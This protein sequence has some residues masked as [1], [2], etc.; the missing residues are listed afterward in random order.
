MSRWFKTRRRMAAGLMA[1]GLLAAAVLGC[2]SPAWAADARLCDA[3][4]LEAI[5]LAKQVREDGCGFDLTNP[6]WSEDFNAHNRWCRSANVESVD[7]ERHVR[8]VN[9][10]ICSQCR[11]YA[12]NARLDAEAAS[13]NK[14]NMA[15]DDAV[16]SLAERA[17][18]ST[19]ED[20]H[21]RWCAGLNHTNPG[22]SILL[23]G[24]TSEENDARS[25]VV[26]DCGVTRSDPLKVAPPTREVSKPF[27]SSR[28]NLSR[29]APG[30]P[31]SRRL[32]AS[33]PELQGT[34]RKSKELKSSQ[35]RTTRFAPCIEGPGQ[36]CG[37]NRGVVGPGLLEG[38]GGFAGQGPS[39]IGAKASSPSATSRSGG[40]APR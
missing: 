38:G 28:S 29:S 1:A 37:G 27:S 18:W 8:R 34:K 6:Q 17:R 40:G 5:K 14:C 12:R 39:A 19:S 22:D 9:A 4:A 3:Y 35:S 26:K 31:G 13:R 2:S 7:A 24:A 20:A 36:P 30:E 33:S 32:R 10:S 23:N 11:V 25:K 15:G 16:M 21:Y